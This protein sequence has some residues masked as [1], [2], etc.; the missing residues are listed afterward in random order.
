MA[1]RSRMENRK[2]LLRR[3]P[4]ASMGPGERK[5]SRR[6]GVTVHTTA[7]LFLLVSIWSDRV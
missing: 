4:L 1:S 3:K 6:E 2:I 7:P 5:V